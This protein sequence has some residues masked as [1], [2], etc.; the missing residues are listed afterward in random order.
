M[1]FIPGDTMPCCMLQS[2][3]LLLIT[4]SSSL[5]AQKVLPDR[6]TFLEASTK[7]PLY[8]VKGFYR[9]AGY[10]DPYPDKTEFVCSHFS[11]TYAHHMAGQNIDVKVLN[12]AFE[13][14][15]GL[16]GHAINMVEL[17][18]TLPGYRQFALVDPQKLQSKNN[19]ILTIF[20][21]RKEPRFLSS[22]PS[23]VIESLEKNFSKKI[24]MR[25]L[26]L[27]WPSGAHSLGSVKSAS[28]LNP[29]ET[30]R[31]RVLSAQFFPQGDALRAYQALDPAFDRDDV[32]YDSYAPKNAAITLGQ[33]A[34]FTLGGAA[35]VVE[36]G[37]LAAAAGVG[38][39][40]MPMHPQVQETQKLVRG[41]NEKVRAEFA[42]EGMPLWKQFL[43]VP[44]ATSGPQ[45]CR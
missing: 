3:I 43:L 5:A 20:H 42:K 10:T 33:L 18:P 25:G 12:I 23:H 38:I 30:R 24:K 7:A 32:I 31:R 28:L 27:D 29:F 39:A 40:A 35:L 4:W 41:H 37:R 11:G 1:F 16:Q 8:G 19:H 9:G 13:A 26:P 2:I 34:A 6:E 22:F 44:P 15:E 36:G 21:S 45:F 17:K 14:G